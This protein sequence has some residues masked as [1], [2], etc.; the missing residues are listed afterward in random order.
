MVLLPIQ[1]LLLEVRRENPHWYKLHPC[2]NL[3]EDRMSVDPEKFACD[4]FWW[5][6][7]AKKLKPATIANIM[8]FIVIKDHCKEVLKLALINIMSLVSHQLTIFC[9]QSPRHGCDSAYRQILVNTGQTRT[10]PDGY[11]DMA[12]F[13]TVSPVL[14]DYVLSEPLLIA[15]AI[16]GSPKP[17]VE[18]KLVCEQNITRLLVRDHQGHYLSKAHR[19]LSEE[20]GQ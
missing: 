18:D 7:Y 10:R 2:P 5:I 16:E 3:Q 20:V 9:R 11:D 4:V 15:L 1:D 8:K 19:M 12:Y 6:Q 13:P 14:A 17:R